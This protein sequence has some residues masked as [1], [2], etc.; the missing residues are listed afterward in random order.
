[1]KVAIFLGLMI[2]CFLIA[3]EA[4]AGEP[5]ATT[6]YV[7]KEGFP[8]EAVTAISTIILS[9]VTWYLVAETKRA[10]REQIEAQRH[11][12]EE[13]F[14]EQRRA[15]TESFA[16]Q[17]RAQ[18][19]LFQEQRLARSVD[20]IILLGN[21]WESQMVTV[22]KHYCGLRVA[23][24]DVD[25]SQRQLLSFFETLGVVVR[26]GNVDPYIAWNKF[27]WPVKHYYALFFDLIKDMRQHDKDITLYNQFEWLNDAF[28][29]I[30]SDE[31]HIP[32][33]SAKPNDRDL[34]QFLKDECGLA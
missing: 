1:M 5:G 30:D 23:K 34:E 20:L 12:Q 19:E 24:C 3:S 11:S 29:K 31:L 13:S 22:R 16:E 21:K 2:A 33:N 17:R 14:A 4:A 25:D 10:V 28:L 27:C 6:V 18:T 8:W 26:R 32:I 7:A 9:M 15:Q